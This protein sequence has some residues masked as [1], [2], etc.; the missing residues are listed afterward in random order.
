[1]PSPDDLLPLSELPRAIAA[2]SGQSPPA[3]GR[4]YVACVSARYPAERVRG[5]WY[6]RR[7]DLGLVAEALGFSA[8][9]QTAS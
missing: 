5:R 7:R 4:V 3:F 6:V 8:L 9:E 2:L 1:M